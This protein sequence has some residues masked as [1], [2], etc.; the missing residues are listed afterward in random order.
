MANTGKRI[1]FFKTISRYGKKKYNRRLNRRLKV[2]KH[3]TIWQ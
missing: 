1:D 3:G 2:K